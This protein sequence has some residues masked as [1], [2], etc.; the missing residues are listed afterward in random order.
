MI[1]FEHSFTSMV[2]TNFIDRARD[3]FG[4]SDYGWL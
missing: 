1:R 4:F 3:K 2:K